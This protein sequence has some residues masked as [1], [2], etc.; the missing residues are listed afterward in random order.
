M[1]TDPPTPFTSERIKQIETRL[2]RYGA[3][4][5]AQRN[6]I[7]VLEL[8]CEGGGFVYHLDDRTYLEDWELITGMRAAKKNLLELC[9][10]RQNLQILLDEAKKIQRRERRQLL[11]IMKAE[12]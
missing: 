1:I 4:V 12:K 7:R 3:K 5:I 6:A 8:I 2:R 9:E 11:R 10:E